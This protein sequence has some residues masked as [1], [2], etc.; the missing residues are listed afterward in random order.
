MPSLTPGVT[1]ATL[2]AFPQIAYNKQSIME[3]QANTPAL[4]ELTDSRPMPRRAGRTQQFYGQVPF[5]A[6]PGPVS[7]AVP[8]PSLSLSQV[9]SQSYCDE[10]GDWVGI[11]NVAK[12]M[13]LADITLDAQRNLAYRGA[14]T[15]NLVVF[16]AFE[17]ASAASAAAR[18]DLTGTMLAQTVKKAE[19]QLMGANVPTRTGGMYSAVM[20]P[21]V[22]YDFTSDQTIGGYL[23]VARRNYTAPSYVNALSKDMTVGYTVYDWAGVR[24]VRTSTVPTYANYPT[25]GL[26][27][28]AS[29]F[30]GREAMISSELLG[31]AV[32][33]DPNFKTR[34]QIFGD[35]DASLSDP[36]LQTR[37]IVSYDWFLGVTARPNTN[38]TPGF[39]R[40]RSQTAAV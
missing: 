4:V 29:Y 20:H 21:Y 17:S 34:V 24:I 10:Y 7:E 33:K 32:P 14:L 40:V 22:C 3:W 11:S 1:S 26:T 18:I 16:N 12:D 31:E 13:F 19:T 9:V 6:A 35:N 8:P 36:L 38:G 2:A 28:Y 25:A 15:A 37:A 27:G 23:D 30:V 39:R 5:T